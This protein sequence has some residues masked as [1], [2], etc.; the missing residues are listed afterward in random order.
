MTCIAWGL[1]RH[2]KAFLERYKDHRHMIVLTTSG[3]GGAPGGVR[4]G[5][6][7]TAEALAEELDDSVAAQGQVESKRLPPAH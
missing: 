1:D 7:K 2:V 6:V 4:A 5:F 3:D